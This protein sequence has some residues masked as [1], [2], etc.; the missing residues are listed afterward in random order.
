MRRLAL[1]MAMIVGWALFGVI[2]ASGQVGGPQLS[3]TEQQATM[4]TFQYALENNKTDQ[5]AAWV[6]PDTDTSGSLVPVR[7]FQNEEGQFCREYIT[8]ITVDGQE[9]QGY[10]TAC[11]QPD[12]TW[13]I[14]SDESSASEGGAQTQGQNYNQT[15]EQTV[16]PAYPAYAAS[17]VYLYPYG[18]P[19]WYLDYPYYV[20]DLY[21]PGIFF[22]Y[23]IVFFGEHHHFHRDHDYHHGFPRWYHAHRWHHVEHAAGFRH[24]RHS[25]YAHS[26]GRR[27]APLRS[28]D[29]PALR[30]PALPTSTVALLWHRAAFDRARQSVGVR[31]FNHVRRI[32]GSVRHLRREAALRRRTL[33]RQHPQVHHRPTALGGRLDAREGR[34]SSEPS[35]SFR[36]G[37]GGGYHGSSHY[38][39]GYHGGGSQRKRASWRQTSLT[40]G[41]QS[42][43]ESPRRKENRPS[44]ARSEG[45]SSVVNPV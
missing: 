44:G 21:Y 5:A 45:R 20:W 18:Y 29:A 9:V 35:R 39:G 34:G 17:P 41:A 4:E 24:G 30:R 1:M 25:D 33:R 6:N 8:T 11:R 40:A 16:E 32:V 22:S 37:M 28:R 7:T 12:G 43:S 14:V 15:L 13:K 42:S 31:H 36:G 3:D 10:G 23:N 2:P 27:L 38:G 19:Y 26:R